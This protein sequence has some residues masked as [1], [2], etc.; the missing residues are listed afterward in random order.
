MDQT[1]DATWTDNHETHSAIAATIRV[2]V[3]AK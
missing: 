3:I 1:I 2:V